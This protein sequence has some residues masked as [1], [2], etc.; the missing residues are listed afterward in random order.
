MSKKPDLTEV[1]QQ[2]LTNDYQTNRFL[3]EVGSKAIIQREQVET[4]ELQ[5]QLSAVLKDLGADIQR[6]SS[7]IPQG[8]EYYGSMAVHIYGAPNTRTVCY[9]NQLALEKCPEALAGPAIS[10]LRNAA[11][12]SYRPGRAQR[13][14]NGF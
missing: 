4:G 13:K 5:H 10:D 1:I 12:E 8:M 6:L 7:S 3:N 14:R 2:E 9:Y 11:I